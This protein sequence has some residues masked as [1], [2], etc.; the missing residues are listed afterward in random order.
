MSFSLVDDPFKSE[1]SAIDVDGGELIVRNE[2][3]KRTPIP[4]ND[5]ILIVLLN[6]ANGSARSELLLPPP[7]AVFAAELCLSFDFSPLYQF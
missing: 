1:F 7:P 4:I 6:F 2:L 5:S 3:I